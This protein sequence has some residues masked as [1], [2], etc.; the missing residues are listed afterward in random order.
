MAAQRMGLCHRASIWI[1]LGS[2]VASLWLPWFFFDQSCGG[3]GLKAHAKE[4][5]AAELLISAALT[6]CVVDNRGRYCSEL[7]LHRWTCRYVLLCIL[8]AAVLLGEF[9]VTTVCD[10]DT[11]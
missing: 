3:L 9:L 2:V 4:Q 5:L 11:I 10:V 6:G 7:S 1:G 8:K